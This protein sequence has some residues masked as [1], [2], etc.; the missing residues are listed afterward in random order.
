M[1]VMAGRVGKFLATPPQQVMQPRHWESQIWF[2][3]EEAV[4]AVPAVSLKNSLV[5]KWTTTSSWWTTKQ[6]TTPDHSGLPKKPLQSATFW[7]KMKLA[8]FEK[9][10]RP[11]AK[12]VRY[13]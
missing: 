7:R 4:I 6:E 13:A 9:T 5:Y 1:K 8:L 2:D 3:Q 10:E 11:A 12:A